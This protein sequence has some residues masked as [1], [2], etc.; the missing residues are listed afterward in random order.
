MTPKA[1]YYLNSNV[2]RV[3]GLR[4]SLTKQYI[5]NLSGVTVTVELIPTVT[6]GTLP[7]SYVPN[8]NG[9]WEV[10]YPTTVGVT[11]GTSY[12][13]RIVATGGS[14]LTGRWNVQLVVEERQDT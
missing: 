5:D 10:V 7:M 4:N 1:F 2:V 13:A 14:Y 6:G 3:V 9:V 11:L 8:S 12:K